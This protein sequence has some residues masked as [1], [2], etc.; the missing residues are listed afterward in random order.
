MFSYMGMQTVRLEVSKATSF[1]VQMVSTSNLI[2]EVIVTGFGSQKKANVTGA[3]ATVKMDNVL[4]NRPVTNV[5]DALQGALPGVSVS[6][7]S[8]QPG[9][10]KSIGIR[11]FSSI[12]GGDPLVLLDNFPVNIEDVNPQ[13]VESVTVLKD[14]SAAAIYGARA[15]FGVV[16]ITSKSGQQIKEKPM[17]FN[18]SST[19][20]FSS[21]EDLPEKAST[22]EFIKALKT[23]G[24]A[25]FWTGQNID[26]WYN[27]LKEYQTNPGKYPKGY[28]EDSGLRY[29]LKD[30][31]V[32]GAW[33]KTG[34]TQIHNFNFS[35]GSNK[36]NYRVSV[37][38]SDEDG[39]IVTRNDSFRRYNINATINSKINRFLTTSSNVIYRNSLRKKT[40]GSY[41]DAVGYGPYVP[42]SG[43]HTFSDGRKY[44][45]D[46]PANMERLKPA[47]EQTRNNIR[48]FQRATLHLL[49][50]LDLTAEYTFYK[51]NS[52]EVKSDNAPTT[53][54]ATRLTLDEG[55]AEDS[56]YERE[57][58]EERRKAFNLYAKYKPS[59]GNHNLALLA[60]LNAEDY[61]EKTLEL[62]REWLI[63]PDLPSFSGATDTPE[64]EDTY[65]SFST[66]GV[67]GR[68]NYNYKEKYFLEMT[69]RYDGSSRFQKGNRFGFFPSF[70]LGW[71]LHKESFMDA[72]GLFSQ[73]KLRGSWGRIGNQKTRSYYPS[74]PGMRM[75]NDGQYQAFNNGVGWLDEENDS[76]YTW[77]R[78][79]RLVSSSFTWETVETTNIGFDAG[80]F[81]NRLRTNFD[82]FIRK[83]LGMIAPGA[84]LPAILGAA[85]PQQNVADL[86]SEGWELAISWQDKIGD[87]SYRIGFTLWDKQAE[88]TK[89]D[90]PKGLLSQHYVGKK[91]GEIWGYETDGF[92]TKDD[93][94]AGSLDAELLNGT[95]KNGVAK[96][97]DV[98]NPNPGDIKYKDLN[99]DGKI[100]WGDNTLKNPGDRKVIGNQTKRYIYGINA[101]ASYKNFDLLV[102][103]NGVGKRDVWH[104]NALRFPYQNQFS[105]VYKSQLDYWTPQNTNAFYPRVYALGGGNYRRSR[106][107]QTK[108]LIDGS[109][110]R[111]RNITLGYTIPSNLTK[112]IKVD[113]F[114]VY[115]S[116]ENLFAFH[117]LPNGIN[118]NVGSFSPGLT[119][120]FMRSYNL[121]VNLTF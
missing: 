114:R 18:Y 118:P 44:P 16:L 12:N 113:R 85:A 94:E 55:E 17:K 21:P 13:D 20:G 15:A 103:M 100:D 70:S 43:D 105:I 108:Y 40:V 86:K 50:G 76:R 28:A 26:K 49:K 11:G 3:T 66:L 5:F 42:A 46:S 84:K 89:F 74:T 24:T 60:G 112:K 102:V 6:G 83:T 54:R 53:V 117:N 91:M 104:S 81:K 34:V 87:F 30:T 25:D 67:F 72:L 78:L 63:N 79:P 96:F 31:D 75:T 92:Y 14:A 33:M 109:Y 120:P 29:P 4:G 97:V 80:F 119:Y 1:N 57:I 106:E 59:F 71:N 22:Y 36:T 82:Y 23:W 73:L 2:D 98:S 52:S 7:S 93:F 116:G 27:Y 77:L 115:L 39:I 121:G 32:I 110:L 61:E 9:I 47:P 62:E 19:Y 88:I 90:N 37:G 48:L 58:V 64:V 95:L 56:S 65:G 45:Y 69:G 10:G 51:A 38:Y 111:V 99:G 8:G 68:L 41:G 107:V 35:G 101:N